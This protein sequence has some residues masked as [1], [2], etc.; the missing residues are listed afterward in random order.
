MTGKH[1]WDAPA[2]KP[3]DRDFDRIAKTIAIKE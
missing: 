2:Q 3:V 1:T